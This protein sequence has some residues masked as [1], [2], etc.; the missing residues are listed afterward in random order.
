[1]GRAVQPRSQRRVRSSSAYACCA[2]Q[3]PHH[4]ITLR[5]SLWWGALTKFKCVV[6]PLHAHGSTVVLRWR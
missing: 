2:E 4:L 6:V 3:L 1:M 5:S